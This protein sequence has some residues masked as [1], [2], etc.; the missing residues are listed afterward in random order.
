MFLCCLSELT[1]EQ[2]LDWPVIRDGMTVI[3]HRLNVCEFVCICV[4]TPWLKFSVQVAYEN[5]SSASQKPSW[6]LTGS[7]RVSHVKGNGHICTRS[8]F[9]NSFQLLFRN[10]IDPPTQA[11]TTLQ[12]VVIN[13]KR[14][15][16]AAS[17]SLLDMLSGSMWVVFR[18]N[19]VFHLVIGP[20]SGIEMES[21]HGANCVAL[22]SLWAVIT[23]TCNTTND[24]NVVTV[25]TSYLQ[26]SSSDNVWCRK[27]WHSG[28]FRIIGQY[29][30]IHLECWNWYH[31]M[32]GDHRDCSAFL[33]CKQHT[34]TIRGFDIW[35][36]LFDGDKG[37]HE[38]LGTER[39][40]LLSLAALYIVATEHW[41]E[42][43]P[44]C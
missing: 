13:W 19:Q 41:S 32:E 23:K 31:M 33:L 7:W 26:C 30:A 40:I 8:N 42:K 3:W 18:G 36:N 10:W 38:R 14:K 20:L 35:D 1:V 34:T 9:V 15:Q 29:I 11:C 21:C 17:L 39:D 4:S 12:V 16:N 2:T 22:P 6:Y 43:L 44:W 28:E 24:D 5:M 37:S 27:I 25:S